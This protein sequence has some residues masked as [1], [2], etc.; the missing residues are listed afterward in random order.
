MGSQCTTGNSVDE[1]VG[2][3]GGGSVEGFGGVAD[4]AVD[5]QVCS[6]GV[7]DAGGE[8]L[9]VVHGGWTA[10]GVSEERRYE[11]VLKGRQ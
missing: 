3:G 9:D 5:G 4:G 7:R 11:G 6:E 8:V 10:R 1:V 2:G